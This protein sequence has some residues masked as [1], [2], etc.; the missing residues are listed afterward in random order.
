MNQ[1]QPFNFREVLQLKPVRRLWLAQV[2]SVVDIFDALTT[3]RPYR[4]A[5]PADVALQILADE[6]TK[7]WRDRVLVDAFVNAVTARPA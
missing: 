2:V 4:V 7:G 6:S 1:P 3:D 5:R